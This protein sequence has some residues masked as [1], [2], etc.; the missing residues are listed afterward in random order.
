MKSIHTY[1][2]KCVYK[3]ASTNSRRQSFEQ[4]NST[5]LSSPPLLF[6]GSFHFGG[7]K[8][9]LIMSQ[10]A[11]LVRV[12]KHGLDGTP[13]YPHHSQNTFY[14]QTLDSISN[15]KYLAYT[16]QR[17]SDHIIALTN[18]SVKIIENYF[19]FKS[20]FYL[21]RKEKQMHLTVFAP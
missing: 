4:F 20:I 15:G 17:P 1:I 18:P 10:S 12:A 11:T 3:S 2:Y 6:F 5:C 9:W 14:Y 16:I 8:F 13:I 21:S 7:V 19:H